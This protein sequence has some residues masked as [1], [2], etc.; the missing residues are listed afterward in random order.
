MIADSTFQLAA[1]TV[2][3]ADFRFRIVLKRN[4]QMAT[5][6]AAEC[7]MQTLR[8]LHIERERRKT[9]GQLFTL[10]VQAFDAAFTRRTAKQR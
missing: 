4:R 8:F 5:D 2:E 7:L 3:R 1:A 6:K 10:G 9:L